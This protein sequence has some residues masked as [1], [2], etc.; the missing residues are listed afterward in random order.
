MSPT[1]DADF[2]TGICVRVTGKKADLKNDL[3]K[4]VVDLSAKV[5]IRVRVRTDILLQTTHEPNGVIFH[6]HSRCRR[7]GLWR[8]AIN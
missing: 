8:L 6:A 3:V 4:F 7:Q 1:E 5:Q 2:T